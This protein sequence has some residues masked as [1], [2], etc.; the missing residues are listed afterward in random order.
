MATAVTPAKTADAPYRKASRPSGVS[1]RSQ[2]QTTCNG[3]GTANR[4][5]ATVDDHGENSSR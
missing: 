2:A 1:E 5:S 4:R 3:P